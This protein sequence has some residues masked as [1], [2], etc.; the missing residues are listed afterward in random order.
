[1]DSIPAEKRD[2]IANILG[3][4]YDHEKQLR[5]QRRK[6]LNLQQQHEAEKKKEVESNEDK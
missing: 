6:M 5:E 2:E 4:F 1:M 3:D